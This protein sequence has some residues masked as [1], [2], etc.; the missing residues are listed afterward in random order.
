MS[1]RSGDQYCSIMRRGCR[2]TRFMIPVH[3]L[4]VVDVRISLLSIKI[5]QRDTSTT[6]KSN[7]SDVRVTSGGGSYPTASR[8]PTPILNPLDRPR[9]AIVMI[10]MEE[11]PHHTWSLREFHACRVRACRTLIDRSGPS[12][13]E[14]AT[15]KVETSARGSRNQVAS[16]RPKAGLIPLYREH[17]YP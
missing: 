5:H 12:L 8:L 1:Y 17:V 4:W 6:R 16:T 9:T 15:V 3:W 2:Q 11:H 13:R 7:S 14:R 10:L